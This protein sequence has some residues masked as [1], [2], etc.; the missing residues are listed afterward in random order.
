MSH[1]L[2]IEYDDAVLLGSGL[3][4]EQFAEEARLLLAA[5]L[6]ELG[7]LSSGQAA[8]WC[9]LSRAA[10]LAMMPRLGVAASNLRPE[11]ADAEL[12]FARHA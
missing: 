6:Y 9:G 5:K 2:R 7:R 8:Q 10:F 12:N 11:D 4:P 3:T 1:A